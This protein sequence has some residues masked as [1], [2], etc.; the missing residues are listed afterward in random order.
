MASRLVILGLLSI[1]VNAIGSYAVRI[2]S[3]R[4]FDQYQDA[5]VY[6]RH[7]AEV[8][9]VLHSINAVGVILLVAAVFANR[10]AAHK[11]A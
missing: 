4:T 5:S 8:Y 6:E 3:Y 10:V 2:H 1:L 7:I 9:A 11:V